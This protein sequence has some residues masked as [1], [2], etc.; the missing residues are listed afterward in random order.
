LQECKKILIWWRGL[1]FTNYGYRG[2]WSKFNGWNLA[3][4]LMIVSIG[5][6]NQAEVYCCVNL[7]SWQ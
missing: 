3:G 5:S 6:Q 1:W 7:T 4:D 2:I